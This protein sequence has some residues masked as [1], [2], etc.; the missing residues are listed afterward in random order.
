MFE[1][2]YVNLM[3]AHKEY[4]SPN[5]ITNSIS[6][7]LCSLDIEEVFEM[8]HPH[9]EGMLLDHLVPLL[10]V[11]TKDEYYKEKDP[12]QFIYSHKVWVDDHNCVKHRASELISLLCGME[13]PDKMRYDIKV[14]NFVSFSMT[15]GVNPRN[16]QTV[17]DHTKEY[18][19]YAVECASEALRCQPKAVMDC[20]G[21]FF[22]ECV[23]PQL[24]SP[25]DLLRVRSC[26]VVAKLGGILSFENS[27][28]YTKLCQGVCSCLSSN[29][30]VVGVAAVEA[31]GVIVMMPENREL[32]KQDLHIIIDCIMDMM[33]KID[34]DDLIEALEQIATQFG[35]SFGPYTERLVNSLSSC[36]YEFRNRPERQEDIVDEYMGTEAA[37]AAEQC[38]D[39]INNILKFNTDEVLF[40][41]LTPYILQLVTS[42][43]MDQDAIYFE[44]CLSL[45]NI[46]LYKSSKID[47]QM[48]E[49][50]PMLC[51]RIMNKIPERRPFGPRVHSLTPLDDLSPA[52]GCF[53]NYMQRIGTNFISSSI[54]GKPYIDWMFEVIQH[55]GNECFQ[56]KDY[57]NLLYS[58]RILMGLIENFRGL[59]DREI[60]KVFCIV[61]EL[62][63]AGEDDQSLK[64]MSMQMIGVLFWYNPTIMMDIMDSK[65]CSDRI[66]H[67]W[68]GS[69]SL[70]ESEH[71]KERELYGIAG[72][73]SLPEA[74][75]P[76]GLL[77]NAVMMEVLKVSSELIEYRKSS[78]KNPKAEMDKGSMEDQIDDDDE[79]D[80][81]GIT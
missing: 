67:V 38:L 16:N 3:R 73:L 50:Y 35:D 7:I 57:R 47:E 76:K 55:I 29:D 36:F 31:M 18:M 15:K 14:M 23:L 51:S 26:S 27:N 44:K 8:V 41:K 75:F 63:E 10:A 45:L 4:V 37:A 22:E 46:L 43:I 70:L 48:C 1:A 28:S 80:S 69:L 32:L 62:M 52:V 24:F 2:S 6:V 59:V 13:A 81:V 65:G 49:F 30:L 78:G 66:L 72:L 33:T 53:L 17:D 54:E 20:I 60:E 64:S 71:E 58:L 68:F 56:S 21:R 42:T 11:N 25:I 9:L 34:L 19:L 77:L 61:V 12:A 79:S 40:N 39:S 5:T 74:R